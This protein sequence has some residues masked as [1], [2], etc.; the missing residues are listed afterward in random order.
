MDVGALSSTAA[1]LSVS[2]DPTIGVPSEVGALSSAA[3]TTSAPSIAA[4]AAEQTGELFSGKLYFVF[5]VLFS[6]S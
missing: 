2:M 5:F 6:R 3:A 4:T 1:T